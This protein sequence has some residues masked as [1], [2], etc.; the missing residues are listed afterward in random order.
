MAW[1]ESETSC[2]SLQT[3]RNLCGSELRYTF[4]FFFSLASE[5]L[6]DQFCLLSIIWSLQIVEE[7]LE[8]GF[9]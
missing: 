7:K 6:K 3:L 2:P 8:I 9:T 5:L 4:V 1:N